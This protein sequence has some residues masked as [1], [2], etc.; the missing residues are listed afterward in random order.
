MPRVLLLITDL[1][2]GGTPTVVRDLALGLRGD[3]FHVEVAC[4]AP[5]GP[6]ADQLADAGVTVTAL[7]A[8]RAWHL[9]RTVRRLRELVRLN[10][11][12]TIVSFL[13]HANFVA[14]LAKSENPQIRLI[15]SIQT[16]QRNPGWHWWLQGR[17]HLAA[18]EML[19]PSAAIVVAAGQRSGIP[20][21]RFVVI[22]NGIDP[23]RFNRAPSVA[24]KGPVV[25][26]GR[27]PD[28][29]ASAQRFSPEDPTAGHG[30]SPDRIRNGQ[31]FDG[32]GVKAGFLGRIDPIKR[33]EIAIEAIG[34]LSDLGGTLDIFGDG[35]DRPALMRR[36][37]ESNAI[38]WRGGTCDPAAALAGMDVLLLPSLG[39]GFGLVLIE[40][41]AAG[42][43]VVA[44]AAGA[45]PEVIEHEKTGLLIAPGRGEIDAFAAAIRR[46]RNDADLRNRLVANGL[47]TVRERYA[48]ESVLAKYRELLAGPTG[49]GVAGAGR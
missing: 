6:V 12:D 48:L 24:V 39:E 33:V 28:P 49:L 5:W 27:L 1:R 47:R 29:I 23:E 40:A 18:S 11:I 37:P 16:T 45:M 36:Y 15:Q 22:P 42:V 38:H 25:D 10:G 7:G 34:K 30:Q 35:A 20:P 4:L 8:T 46:L 14:T 41:M 43:P 3:D 44:S 32:E 2:I 19:A 31:P 21:E 13:L 9:P 26:P 17:I